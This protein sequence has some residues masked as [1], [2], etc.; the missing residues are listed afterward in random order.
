MIIR[1]GQQMAAPAEG[2]LLWGLGV[3][4]SESD[5]DTTRD[6]IMRKSGGNNS[7][8]TGRAAAEAHLWAVT[9][10]ASLVRTAKYL[11]STW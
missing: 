3:A 4:I 11:Q 8:R 2:R 5:N 1:T 10:R 9:T 6:I 7:N